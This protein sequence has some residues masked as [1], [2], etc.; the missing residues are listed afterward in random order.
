MIDEPDHLTLL[1]AMADTLSDQ[2][3]PA[4]SGG[5][6]HAAR[7]VANLCRI[8]ARDSQSGPEQA[9]TIEALRQLLAGD[10]PDRDLVAEL[11]QLIERGERL[12]EILP[13]L[14]TDVTRRAEIA[15]PGY[16]HAPT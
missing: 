8:L 15:R 3:V 10:G 16:T 11:D 5:A 2:V 12:D 13:L 9:R 14:L 7:V 4:T 6:Q 1:N